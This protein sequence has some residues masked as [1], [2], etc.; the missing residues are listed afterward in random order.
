[1]D[2]RGFFISYNKA[3][4]AWAKWIA[5]ILEEEGYSIWLQAWDIRP[6]DD[7]MMA[8]MNKFLEN[9]SAYIPV[10]SQDFKDSRYCQLELSAALDKHVNDPSYRFLPVRIVK[11]APPDL[12][13]AIVYIDLFGVDEEIAKKRLLNA[14]DRKQ[15]PRTPPAFSGGNNVGSPF[16]VNVTININ[17]VS[18]NQYNSNGGT[19]N[20]NEQ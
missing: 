1:M 4:K 2:K 8:R 16:P 9:S 20:V 12:I 7:F 13:R 5:G 18:G 11:V 19:I 14:V 6:G 3:D 15:I 10:L 17:H